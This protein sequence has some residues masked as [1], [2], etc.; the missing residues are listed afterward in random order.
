MNWINNY[1]KY[2]GFVFS[3]IWRLWFFIVFLIVF[4][5]LIPPLYF[6]TRIIP[7][8]K[9]V[10]NIT[11]LWSRLTLL[12]SGVF[13]NVKYEKKIDENEN[14][15]ICP[16]H[17]STIDIPVILAALKLP[18][19]FMAKYEYS[20]IPIFGWFYKNNTVQVRRENNKDAYS[21]FLSAN[22]KL[23]NG[24]N[25]CIFPEGGVPPPDVKLRRFKN[26][27][28]KLAIESNTKIIPVTMP[29][30]KS[31]FPWNYFK[32]KPG[33]LNIEVHAPIW[34]RDE[35]ND[36]KDLNTKVYNTIFEKLTDYEN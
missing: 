16:N 36:I 28:F 25:V 1:M 11:R 7:N 31:H 18:I 26:G 9:T 17:I 20:K 3:S 29:D 19:I 27:P 32:G 24:L 15:I 13:L 22:E 21:A 23:K 34:Q 8:Q 30:N 33:I 12:F 10:C 14:Y 4:I 2:V 35:T 6:F 5:I